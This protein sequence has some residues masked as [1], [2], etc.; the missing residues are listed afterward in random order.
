MDVCNDLQSQ[1][2]SR[3]STLTAMLAEQSQSTN[4]RIAG[5]AT[6][7]E[8]HVTSADQQSAERIDAHEHITARI[9][10]LSEELRSYSVES[11][12]DRARIA[13]IASVM[14]ELQLVWKAFDNP[15]YTAACNP[16]VWCPPKLAD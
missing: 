14:H 8:I 12:A 1:F 11:G 9:A 3:I 13:E 5:L 7:L 4:D 6:L 15:Q 16:F 2:E 10:G